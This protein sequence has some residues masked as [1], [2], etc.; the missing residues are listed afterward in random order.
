MLAPTHSIFGVFLTLIILG[1]FGIPSSLH[2]PVLLCA[3]IGSLAPDL[4]TEKSLVGKLFPFISEP[5]E[6]KF[7]HRSVTHSIIGWA[8]ASVIFSLLLA[9][10]LFIYRQEWPHLK[11][12]IYQTP[13]QLH[14]FNLWS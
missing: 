5:I 1:V 11:E 10:F 7:G 14:P 6:R 13:A 12:L 3:V 9:F 8:I 4:D 2:W